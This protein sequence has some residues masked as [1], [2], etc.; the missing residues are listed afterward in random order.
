MGKVLSDSNLEQLI[1]KGKTGKINGFTGGDGS[2]RDGRL[3]FDKEFK[4]V[5]E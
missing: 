4:V 2:K 1:L 3:M 5:L